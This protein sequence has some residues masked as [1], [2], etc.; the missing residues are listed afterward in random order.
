MSIEDLRLLNG[1][2]SG[3]QKWLSVDEVER[4]RRFRRQVE[5]GWALSV[6]QQEEVRVMVARARARRKSGQPPD[7]P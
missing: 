7:G 1:A 5:I 6:T 4:L 2:L 3:H